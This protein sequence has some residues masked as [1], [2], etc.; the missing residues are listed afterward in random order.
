MPS[1]S[2]IFLSIARIRHV[3]TVVI[4]LRSK[5]SGIVASSV[6]RVYDDVVKFHAVLSA[7]ADALGFAPPPINTSKAFLASLRTASTKPHLTV[8]RLVSRRTQ[9]HTPRFHLAR[10]LKPSQA[11][12]S[13]STPRA[14]ST[15]RVLRPFL[16]F[17][18][19]D[20]SL[21]DTSLP[22]RERLPPGARGGAR[23]DAH[24]TRRARAEDARRCAAPLAQLCVRVL[25]HR[26]ATPRPPR[27]CFAVRIARAVALVAEGCLEADCLLPV[28]APR[29]WPLCHVGLAEIDAPVTPWSLR[30]LNAPLGLLP[31]DVVCLCGCACGRRSHRRRQAIPPPLIRPYAAPRSLRGHSWAATPSATR[32]SSR[33]SARRG[34]T[35]TGWCTATRARSPA[36]PPRRPRARAI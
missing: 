7:A 2:L 23:K 16:S 11:T 6:E 26:G 4:E 18:E 30:G 36:R 13:T 3:T 22:N 33:G 32:C 28:T 10:I 31:A 19:G 1:I 15:R 5:E 14:T 17:E 20:T 27:S 12:R 21:C 8:T 35:A 34:R 9:P 24:R 29:A 25:Q